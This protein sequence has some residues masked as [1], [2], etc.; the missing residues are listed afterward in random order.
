MQWLTQ[1]GGSN[2][3]PMDAEQAGAPTE[4]HPP[5]AS[6]ARWPVLAIAA[7]VGLVLLLTSGRV[8][9]FVDEL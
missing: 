9:Y 7:G 4:K 6:L 8:G 5:I 3:L 2:P 1:P